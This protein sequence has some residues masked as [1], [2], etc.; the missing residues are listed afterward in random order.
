MQISVLPKPVRYIENSAVLQQTAFWAG[1]KEHLGCQP[2]AF[3]I[4][5]DAELAVKRNTDKKP[6]AAT[7]DL[8]VLLQPVGGDQCIAHIPYGPVIEP[9]EE[10]QGV[11]LEELSESLRPHL[12]K[13]CM[14][15][16]YDL[17][18]ESCWAHDE[19]RF[20]T[21]QQWL[22]PPPPTV[23]EMRINFNTI[24][25][26][27]RKTWSDNLP[28][29]TV[30]ISLKKENDLLLKNM[31]PKTRYNI[32]LAQRRGVTVKEVTPK[33]LPAWY[34][35]YQETALRNHL[36]LQG[37]EYFSSILNAKRTVGDAATGLHLLMAEKDG[38]PLAGM[39]LTITG[40]R[41][42][43][44]YGASSTHQ[45]NLMATYAL[46]WAAIKKAKKQGC[47]EY[48]M[49]G[50]AQPARPSHPLYGLYRFKTGFGGNIFRRMGC[51]DY[52]LD[53]YQY[54]IFRSLEMNSTGYH[55]K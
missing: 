20:D 23:Q 36:F 19:D 35:L 51:W 11:L 14:L 28:S 39:F 29:N 8:L 46:Q 33:S 6:A 24:K 41:A 15:I 7:D 54:E 47:V 48:D 18:W 13:R 21:D 53:P 12:P 22:G 4:R 37:I 9:E 16:R 5:I 52:P 3:D 25:N 38:L 40:G 17:R 42:T 2:K 55:L 50:I 32:Q 1:V 27:L 44:L 10:L 30:F 49:F 45:R 31:K 43:Y 34:A 26:N